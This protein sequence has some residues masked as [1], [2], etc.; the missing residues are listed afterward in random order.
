VIRDAASVSSI[1]LRRQYE[2]QRCCIAVCI[3]SV[4]VAI[5]QFDHLLSIRR[6]DVAGL[7]EDLLQV[8]SDIERGECLCLVDVTCLR[9]VSLA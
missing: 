5:G 3:H 1:D 4:H 9:A 8:S 6:H 2:D 7:F